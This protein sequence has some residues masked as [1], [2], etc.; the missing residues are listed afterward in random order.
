[1]SR[2][3][4]FLAAALVL[5][6]IILAGFF[7]VNN[8]SQGTF[9]EE[10]KDFPV[11]KV[12]PQLLQEP[13]VQAIEEQRHVS[14]E[15]R[16]VYLTRWSAGS[17]WRLSQVLELAEAG[18][19]NALVVD[20]KDFSGFLAYDTNVQQAAAIGAEQRNIKDPKAYVEKLHSAGLYSIAR[21]TVFQDPVLAQARPDLAIKKASVEGEIWKDHK[22]LSWVDPASRE[23]WEYNIAIAKDALANGFDEVNFD[24]VRFPSDGPIFD[25]KYPF[26][27]EK[28]PLQE[29]IASFFSYVSSE[30]AEKGKTSVDLFGLAAANKWDDMGIGQVLEDAF[31]NFD[32]ISP[33]IYPSHFAQGFLGFEHTE[34]HPYE[35]VHFSMRRAKERMEQFAKVHGQRAKLRPW[36]QYFDLPDSKLAYTPSVIREQIQATKDALGEEYAGYLLWNSANIYPAKEVQ[37][38]M[39]EAKEHSK[40]QNL[41]LE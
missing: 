5:G 21:I 33:M 41:L 9:K 7:I 13:K 29:I 26:W 37:E 3:V 28:T 22:G 1:M 34:Q 15:L 36:L 24:Y 32:F 19:V 4:S 18:L 14:K 10:S 27:D 23:V 30:L 35:I 39:L 12:V 25:T 2:A 38:I 16:G 40:E 17:A 8:F 6:G 11:S 20:I 31:L